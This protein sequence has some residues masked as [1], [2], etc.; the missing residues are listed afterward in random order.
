[1]SADLI[2][3]FTVP[4]VVGDPALEVGLDWEGV[5]I[6]DWFCSRAAL[7]SSS[8]LR[9]SPSRIPSRSSKLACKIQW[10]SMHSQR[11]G[12]RKWCSCPI[13]KAFGDNTTETWGNS[14][15]AILHWQLLAF[16]M[17]VN[18]NLLLTRP[19]L[20]S[21]LL[22]KQTYDKI[23]SKRLVILGQYIHFMY[24]IFTRS[25]FS[26]LFAAQFSQ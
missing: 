4:V 25:Q 20:F 3:G 2:R 18:I 1:M 11:H 9:R 22:K 12:D 13:Q 26:N 21:F 15:I 17:Y 5:L 8:L 10:E 24:R 7:R 16:N 6:E 14:I 23:V 19:K